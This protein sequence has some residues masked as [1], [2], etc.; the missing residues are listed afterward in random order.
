[1]RPRRTCSFWVTGRCDGLVL[2]ESTKP[3]ETNGFACPSLKAGKRLSEYLCSS[4]SE[5][6]NDVDDDDNNNNNIRSVCAYTNAYT[7][8]GTSS[9]HFTIPLFRLSFE[10]GTEFSAGTMPVAPF[11]L[12]CKGREMN[13]KCYTICD[14]ERRPKNACQTMWSI[15]RH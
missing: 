9:F 5:S 1:M 8:A 12:S 13:E 11:F 6:S 2:A 10:D 15:T 3:T 7:K 14:A 4:L